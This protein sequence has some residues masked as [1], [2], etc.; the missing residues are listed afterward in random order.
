MEVIH[1]YDLSID[2]IAK[3]K[4][5]TSLEVSK[6]IHL[7]QTIFPE[8]QKF[9]DN[10]GNQRGQKSGVEK[11]VKNCKTKLLNYSFFSY[12]DNYDIINNDLK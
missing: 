3:L 4:V 10:E 5:K 7:F 2:D 8:F 11:E 1:P 12:Y 6:M 9:V